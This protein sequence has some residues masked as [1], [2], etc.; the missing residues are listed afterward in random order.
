M[1]KE[2]F[3]S[4]IAQFSRSREIMLRELHKII[5]GQDDVLNQI[6]A[7]IITRGHC[8]LVGVPGLAKTLIVSSLSKIMELSFKRV[9]FTPD[10]MPSDITGT[11]VIDELDSGRREFRFVPGPVFANII[12]ADEINRTPP[13]TQAAMLE[14]MQER[15]VT[16]GQETRPLPDPFFVI[17]TQNPIEQEGTY[18]LPEA[19]LDRFMFNIFVDYPSQDEEEQILTSTTGESK[20]E[21]NKVFNSRQIVNMQRIVAKVPVSEYVVKYVANLVRATR[22]KNPTAPD[23]VK[24]M[25]D[26]GAGPRA[27]Q[28]LIHGAKAFAAM[29]GRYTVS[30]QD[31]RSVAVPVLRHRIGCNFAAASAGLDSVSIVSKLIEHVPEPE[32]P[33]YAPKPA[34]PEV[35]TTDAVPPLPAE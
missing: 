3:E 20:P 14:A 35:D 26:W 23:F 31:V 21:L 30:I 16:V 11:N 7:C 33:K 2:S 10:L 22:P 13:K 6:F 25:V 8:L 29:D 12:L 9:Q 32:V 5:I 19:Q 1:A 4:I 28:Y 18:P 34:P 27:G 24:E 17:A 15:Q